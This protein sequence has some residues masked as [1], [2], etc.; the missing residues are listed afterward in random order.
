MPKLKPK[1][2]HMPQLAIRA[3]LE[4]LDARFDQDLVSLPRAI[5]TM[6]PWLSEG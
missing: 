2:G 3:M 5:E 6:D 4:S 1:G